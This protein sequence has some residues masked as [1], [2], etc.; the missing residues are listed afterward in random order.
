MSWLRWNFFDLCLIARS[1]VDR[2]L[3]AAQV[4][5]QAYFSAMAIASSKT[6]S[7]TTRSDR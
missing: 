1:P 3:G 4:S 2:D 5:L 6:A 7:A